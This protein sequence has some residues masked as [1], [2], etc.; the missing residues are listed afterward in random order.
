MKKYCNLMVVT[1]VL[2]LFALVSCQK[3]DYSDAL[4][5]ATI[6][7]TSHADKTSI[8]TSG[9]TRTVTWRSG[10]QIAVFSGTA[11]W[12]PNAACVVSTTST[13]ATA[14]FSTIVSGSLTQSATVYCAIYPADFVVTDPNCQTKSSSI[15][16]PATQTYHSV[17]SG[18]IEFAAPMY[19]KTTVASDATTVPLEFKNLCG[20]VQM[21]VTTSKTITGIWIKSDD[22]HPVCGQFDVNWNNGQPTM[23]PVTG[24]TGNLVEYSCGAVNCANGASF[25]VYLPAGNYANMEFT[26]LA[27]DGTHSILKLRGNET[28]NVSRSM[29]HPLTISDMQFIDP[30]EGYFTVDGNGNRVSFSSGNLQYNASTNTWRFAEHQYDFVGADNINIGS[31]TYTGWIDLF[32]WGTGSNPT[33]DSQENA[34]YPTFIDWGTNSIADGGTGWFTLSKE[35]WEYLLDINRP[36][37]PVV[38]RPARADK[39]GTAT[40]N[41]IHGLIILP[42][43]WEAAHPSGVD[44]EPGYHGWGITNTQNIFSLEQWGLM[45]AYG[46]IFLPT[47]GDRA[48]HL[49]TEQLSGLYWSST[50]IDYSGAYYMFIQGGGNYID[51]TNKDRGEGLSVRLVKS[52][53]TNK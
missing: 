34:D 28:F 15:D 42:D 41:G 3:E 1:C 52:V 45:E 38:S 23:S 18:K 16:L 17:E 29:L 2:A 44:F 19:T 8:A 7:G 51:V 46:A 36:G 37:E 6:E 14:D 24:K 5:I 31:S 43:N 50:D 48:S 10:D 47:A 22:A 11:N 39:N 35:Q 49:M 30:L 27:T 33:E 40:V 53:S 12:I 26:F 25:Y 9:P 4:F 20:V 32:G 21:N 13:G